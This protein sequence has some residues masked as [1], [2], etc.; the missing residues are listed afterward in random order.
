MV[1]VGVVISGLMYDVVFLVAKG[2]TGVTD[3]V[4]F[5]EVA[6]GKDRVP[7][8]TG[9]GVGTGEAVVSAVLGK[10]GGMGVVVVGGGLSTVTVFVLVSVYTVLVALEAVVLTVTKD[11]SEIGA[12]P[13][14]ETVMIGVKAAEYVVVCVVS[15]VVSATSGGGVLMVVGPSMEVVV[16][17][18]G[19]VGCGVVAMVVKIG[20]RDSMGLVEE[21]SKNRAV[22]AKGALLVLLVLGLMVVELRAL[23]V[24][25]VV[26][27]AAEG[28]DSVTL[29]VYSGSSTSG[30]TA[31]GTV[32]EDVGPAVLA[33]SGAAGGEVVTGRVGTSGAGGASV[34]VVSVLTAGTAV[35][36]LVVGPVSG[37]AEDLVVTVL[38]RGV[39]AAVLVVAAEVMAAEIS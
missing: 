16:S 21:V 36:I 10:P 14:L 1:T 27:V 30:L 13:G 37:G 24:H 25:A 9:G 38:R 23:V 39:E 4:V 32:G 5:A 31:G 6:A 15:S 18:S 33:S 12:R 29:T 22:M 11:V 17:A 26:P 2:A 28:G 34:E 19:V 3:S 8:S 7:V 20:C 35:V